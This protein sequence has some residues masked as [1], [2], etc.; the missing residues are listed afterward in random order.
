MYRYDKN[1]IVI[2]KFSLRKQITFS[3]K[4]KTDDSLGEL[5]S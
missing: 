4:N 3:I 5:Q 1:M 2:I